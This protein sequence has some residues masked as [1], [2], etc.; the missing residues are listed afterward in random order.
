[1]TT[2]DLQQF[3]IDQGW[4]HLKTMWRVKHGETIYHLKGM[5]VLSPCSWM[6]AM[7]SMLV[8]QNEDTHPAHP[9]LMAGAASLFKVFPRALSFRVSQHR[10]QTLSTIVSFGNMANAAASYCWGRLLWWLQIYH[11]ALKGVKEEFNWT[12]WQEGVPGYIM[13]KS[14]RLSLAT[15]SPTLYPPSRPHRPRA[16]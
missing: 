8:Q 2:D 16:R 4:K 7:V 1:M 5:P 9:C 14:D 10:I 11:A 6:Y 3:E 15:G 13:C 12:C